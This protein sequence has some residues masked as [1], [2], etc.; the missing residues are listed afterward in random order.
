MAL[1]DCSFSHGEIFNLQVKLG[2]AERKA[3]KWVW[4]YSSE[5]DLNFEA[6]I[7]K[8]PFQACRKVDR[9]VNAWAALG[10]QT[11]VSCGPVPIGF[12]SMPPYLVLPTG[13]IGD[14]STTGSSFHTGLANPDDQTTA[15][16]V[17]TEQKTLHSS[18]WP[19]LKFLFKKKKSKNATGF[20]VSTAVY[21]LWWTHNLQLHS[22]TVTL[23]DTMIHSVHS[24]AAHFCALQ[25]SGRAEN[26][27][28]LFIAPSL[29][30]I[31][32]LAIW[33]VFAA[34]MNEGFVQNSPLS[35]YHI[36]WDV[37]RL[38]E[39]MKIFLLLD[40]FASRLT[41]GGS[42]KW[43]GKMDLGNGLF[44]EI[45]FFRDASTCCGGRRPLPSSARGAEELAQQSLTQPT[46]VHN[47]LLLNLAWTYNPY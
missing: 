34:A 25:S 29:Q 45:I 31:I 3:S 16:D 24:H 4:D 47:S 18:C 17:E 21:L 14:Q 2:P 39:K 10:P 32:M 42:G 46:S 20:I 41:P 26:I 9:D 30:C 5:F 15:P 35:L 38:R 7:I 1:T 23:L 44:R 33:Q 36:I 8:K 28:I 40:W 27:S 6:L 13:T 11:A 43:P 37:L 19:F 22:A 12:I